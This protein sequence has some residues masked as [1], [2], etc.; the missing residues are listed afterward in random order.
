MPNAQHPDATV[1]LAAIIEF[2]DSAIVS[3]NLDGI[4]LT[5]NGAAKRIYGYTAD[6]IIGKPITLLLAPNCSDE[7]T[8]I[9]SRIQ[10]GERVEQFETV[11]D[12][13]KT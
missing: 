5:W 10:R 13:L 2:S 4:I 1:Q 3:K 6:E 8:H 12:R 9:L 7:E 11:S